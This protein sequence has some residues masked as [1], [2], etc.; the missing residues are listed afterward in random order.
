M[1]AKCFED[2]TEKQLKS[3]LPL[4][5]QLQRFSDDA[6]STLM[7][8]EQLCQSLETDDIEKIKWLFSAKILKKPFR[9][10]R[11]GWRWFYLPAENF[12][13]TSGI[14]LAMSNIYFLRFVKN[15]DARAFA[16]L[17]SIVCR[18]RR[19]NWWFRRFRNDY[20][21]DDRVPYN[22]LKSEAVADGFR[23]LPIGTAMAIFMYWQAMNE[24][25]MG[26]YG[27][28]FEGDESSKALFE[29]GEG[30]I[31]TLEDVAKDGVHGN[32]EKVCGVNVHTIFMYLKHNKIKADEMIRQSKK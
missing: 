13:N 7:I 17:L 29:N 1:I 16:H 4:L 2:L 14:E 20:D 10:V 11:I 25:F 26:D 6:D 31:A 12:L 18:P 27:E 30:W 24:K 8:V 19:W 23:K 15:N 21:S 9:R 32:F 28:V 3:V 5:A 22:S